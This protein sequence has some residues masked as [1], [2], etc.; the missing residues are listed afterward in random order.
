MAKAA[1]P[2]E[3]KSSSMIAAWQAVHPQIE[4]FFL[5]F[6]C[7]FNKWEPESILCIHRNKIQTW[8]RLSSHM[9]S[10]KKLCSLGQAGILLGA[11]SSRPPYFVPIQRMSIEV[12]LWGLFGLTSMMD[13]NFKRWIYKKQ[14]TVLS[15][16]VFHVIHFLTKKVGTEF[17]ISK[18]W[19]SNADNGSVHACWAH[20]N[21][22]EFF[23]LWH[24]R[25]LQNGI[26]FTSIAILFD[27]LGCVPKICFWRTSCSMV[28]HLDIQDLR[29]C[30]YLLAA[31]L[32]LGTAGF[33]R[34]KFNCMI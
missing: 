31:G 34:Y 18:L 23:L 17:K 3:V 26:S 16:A 19:N 5:V 1:T 10:Q 7:H 12:V 11:C 9:S 32:G 15:L 13:L 29:W 14:A 4:I 21:R 6:E 27:F 33:D 20:S 22:G 24:S 2:I 30:H 8:P 25:D 28:L